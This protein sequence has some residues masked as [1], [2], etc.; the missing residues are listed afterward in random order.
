[1]VGERERILTERLLAPHEAAIATAGVRLVLYC[2]VEG[3]L[4]EAVLE[5]ITG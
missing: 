1:M 5:T 2:D 4:D 3:E